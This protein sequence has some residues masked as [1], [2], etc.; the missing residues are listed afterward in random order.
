MAIK[1]TGIE[2]VVKVTAEN[3]NQTGEEI[4]Y[5]RERNRLNIIAMYEY[6][7]K[8]N[9]NS[10]ACWKHAVIAELTGKG[11]SSIRAIIDELKVTK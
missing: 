8:E 2:E 10:K 6:L 5:S 11:E 7:S 9:P 1:F 3:F 4:K